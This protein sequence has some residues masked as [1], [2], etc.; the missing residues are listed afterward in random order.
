[1]ITPYIPLYGEDIGLSI[2]T[3]GYIVATYNLVQFIGKIPMGTLSDLIGYKKVILLGGL[4]LFSATTSYLLSPVLWPLLFLAQIFLGVTV[5]MEWVTLPAYITQFGRGKIPIF[6]FII[7][8]AY[9]ISVPFTGFLKDAV[10]MNI[11]FILAFLLSI[12]SIII[13]GFIR[14]KIPNQKYI[15]NMSTRSNS[16][17]SV[18]KNSFK[19]LKN[20]GVRRASLYTFLMFMNFNIGLS[21][22]PLY[23][24]GLG[25]TATLIGIIQFSRMSISTSIRLMIEKIGERINLDKILKLGTLTV[26][27]SLVLVSLIESIHML[28]IVSVIWGLSSGLYSPIVYSMIADGTEICD[29]GKGMGMRGTMGSLGSFF[30]IIIFSNIAELLSISAAIIMS[31]F[32]I[33]IG[34][35][36]IENFTSDKK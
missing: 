9:T 12:L 1:M 18:Y 36:I 21:L 29:R 35:I 6:T 19:T 28:I 3:I 22:F 32:T 13:I 30:G 23:L 15:K 34:V 14:E 33:I 5:C 24:S 2:S 25:F 4:S 20:P 8:W 26:G 11:I 17:K 31:G 7:G 16:I 10:G 27:I